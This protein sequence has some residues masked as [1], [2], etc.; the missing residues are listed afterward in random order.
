MALRLR[1][2]ISNTKTKMPKTKMNSL[3]AFTPKIFNR[4]NSLFKTELVS[5]IPGL[6]NTAINGIIEATP[7]MSVSAIIKIKIKIKLAF[8]FS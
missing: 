2:N 6:V 5:I 8:C 3:I 1:E 7:I 4:S